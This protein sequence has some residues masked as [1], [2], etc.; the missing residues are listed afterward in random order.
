MGAQMGAQ[1]LK[2]SRGGC[3]SSELFSS[4]SSW[5]GG[6]EDGCLKRLWLKT[7]SSAD[8]PIVCCLFSSPDGDGD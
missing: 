2:L 8:L 1:K 3:S 7:T 6:S 5:T 4:D